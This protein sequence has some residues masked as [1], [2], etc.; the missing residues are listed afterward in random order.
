VDQ[1]EWKT[2][3]GGHIKVRE[4]VALSWI[5]LSRIE[6][7]IPGKD[8]FSP[9]AMYRNKGA[10]VAAYNTLMG[11]DEISERVKGQI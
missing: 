6:E 2:N 1:I 5:P 3:E 11:S 4:L 10:C 7:K 9:V 8:E